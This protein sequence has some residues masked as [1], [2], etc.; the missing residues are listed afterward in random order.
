MKK[1][2][3]GIKPT[4]ALTLGNYIG[5][6]KQYIEMQ[7]DYESYIFIANMHAIT[8]PQNKDELKK[9][10]RDVIAI[11]LACGLD[12]ENA[13]IFLQSE[14]PYHAQLTWILDCNSYMGELNRMTQFKDK[15]SKE[16]NDSITCGL[17]NYPVLMASDIIIYDADVVPVGIDQKQH[18]EL[19]RNIAERFN[20]KYGI[21]FKVPEPVLP[22]QGAKIKDLQDPTKKMSKSEENDKGVILLLEDLEITKK[23]IMS[24]VTD[25]DNK[26]LFDEE[27]KPGISNL[28]TI[29][30]SLSNMSIK[31][32]EDK[33]KDANYG[34]FKKDVSE[35]VVNTIK[36]IQDKYN[37]IINSDLIDKIL[38]KG[39]KKV[40]P[41]AEAKCLEVQKKI[42][43]ER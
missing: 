34:A 40:L 14:N 31:D 20:N 33:Y 35:I 27:N 22:K 16:N 15:S 41:I 17:Y 43:L 38:D 18:V 9:R 39:I 13:T 32:I 8:T 10:T 11:Y 1:L 4:G 12:Y 6:L 42:G 26:I 37:E 28:I 25:S 3:S 30:A 2:V 23:K 7:N 5:A 36:P 24:A 19:T 29:Y 21:T